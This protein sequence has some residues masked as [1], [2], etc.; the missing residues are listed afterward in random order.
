MWIKPS[1]PAISQSRR[2]VTGS[3]EEAGTEGLWDCMC[4]REER[5]GRL[6]TGWRSRRDLGWRKESRLGGWLIEPPLQGQNQ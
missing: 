1:T 4:G 6:K 2:M 5:D 3:E